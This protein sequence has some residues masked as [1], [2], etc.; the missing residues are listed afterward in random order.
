MAV[1]DRVRNQ[2][3]KVPK[4]KSKKYL[5]SMTE[6]MESEQKE[7]VV[8][9]ANGHSPMLYEINQDHQS[10]E[11]SILDCQNLYSRLRQG[12]EFQLRCST[13]PSLLTAELLH[14][15]FEQM[16]ALA[17]QTPVSN[18][19]ERHSAP[20]AKLEDSR[21]CSHESRF[22][23]ICHESSY[24]SLQSFLASQNSRE[25]DPVDASNIDI[26]ISRV[27]ASIRSVESQIEARALARAAEI[28]HTLMA[29]N[30]RLRC[31]LKEAVYLAW[32]FQKEL[33]PP[34]WQAP[35][36]PYAPV[37]PVADHIPPPQQGCPAG[38]P[39]AEDEWARTPDRRPPSAAPWPPDAEPRSAATRAHHG[40]HPA[41]LEDSTI[42]QAAAA[43]E[44]SNPWP[45]AVHSP[46]DAGPGPT[47]RAVRVRGRVDSEALLR[48]VRGLEETKAALE[49]RVRRLEAHLLAA[50]RAAHDSPLCGRPP[51]N[52][53]S[54][55]PPPAVG[56]A[57]GCAGR[58][59][60]PLRTTL[61]LQDIV[62]QAGVK[63]ARVAA[64]PGSK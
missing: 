37:Q 30:R 11:G 5:R 21:D 50:G 36:D 62:W 13:S 2:L 52:R 60:G 49:A 54:P 63:A 16:L 57:A 8:E 7:N 41:P 38:S 4:L 15:D 59:G 43:S 20:R 25:R 55:P 26:I 19:S 39:A 29:E 12:I 48:H 9:I 10:R 32:C 1:K 28:H 6:R 56:A 64:P 44:A 24:G 18:E 51:P 47:A 42:P 40:P 61:R 31:D 14:D 3:G 27:E 22:S 53:P 58:A 23:H 35:P 45:H 33:R 17:E 46:V 34:H